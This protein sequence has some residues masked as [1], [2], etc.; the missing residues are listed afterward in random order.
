MAGHSGEFVVYAICCSVLSLQMLLLAGVTAARR[1]KHKG[2][3]NPEDVAVSFAEARLIEGAEHPEVARVIRAHRNLQ[4]SL[5]MFFALGLI[6]V[7]AG[8]PALGAKVCFVGFTAARVLH[9]IAYLKGLQPWR[10]VMYAI[11]SL[12]LVGMIALSLWTLLSAGG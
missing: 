11:G 10:T 4:E 9:T 8:A 12:A 1:A 3:S 7:L 6:Y 5:P 2:Y